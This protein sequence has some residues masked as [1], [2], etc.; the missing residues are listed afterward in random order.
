VGA[1]PWRFKSSHPHSQVAAR[2]GLFRG[3]N[4]AAQSGR[5]L[6]S[7]RWPATQSCDAVPN[8]KA[9]DTIPLPHRALR[10]VAVRDA[11]AEQPPA[12]IVEDV[13]VDVV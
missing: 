4:V 11:D 13:E 12:L 7:G 3:L 1:T 5:P 6:A 2:R 10:V 9:G 8:W